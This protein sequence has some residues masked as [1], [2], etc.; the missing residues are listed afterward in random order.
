MMT[1]NRPKTRDYAS[2]YGKYI[3]L[4]PEGELLQILE[5]QLRDWQ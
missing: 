3:A 1:Q 5:A 4:V 2:F